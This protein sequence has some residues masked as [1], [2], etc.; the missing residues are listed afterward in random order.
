MNAAGFRPK[1]GHNTRIPLVVVV[2]CFPSS[3]P[4][5]DGALDLA[6]S[7]TAGPTVERERKK[8]RKRAGV[9][10]LTRPFTQTMAIPP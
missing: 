7:D 4:E 1:H 3:P 6:P 2:F 8:L 10:N 9:T 5:T